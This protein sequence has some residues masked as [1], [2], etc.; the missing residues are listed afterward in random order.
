MERAKAAHTEGARAGKCKRPWLRHGKRFS[1]KEGSGSSLV[2]GRLLGVVWGW[3]GCVSSL[4]VVLVRQRFVR[5]VPASQF[6]V[7]CHSGG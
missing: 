7:F 1:L 6:R 4:L 2:H 3:L 5:A